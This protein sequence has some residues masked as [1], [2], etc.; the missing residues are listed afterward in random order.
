MCSQLPL[1]PA[2][3]LSARSS[4]RGRLRYYA[5]LVFREIETDL[6]LILEHRAAV[7]TAKG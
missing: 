7:C 1:T 2:A 6:D 5:L 3:I 4:T